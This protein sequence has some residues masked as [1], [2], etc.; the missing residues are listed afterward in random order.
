MQFVQK[1]GCILVSIVLHAT[2]IQGQKKRH[3]VDPANI[4]TLSISSNYLIKKGDK[5]ARQR[6]QN[7][8]KMHFY[9]S[10]TLF[11][12]QKNTPYRLTRNFAV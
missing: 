11:Y 9:N 4:D 2:P 8:S 1:I 3:T 5:A 12:K 10:V 7:P 6:R